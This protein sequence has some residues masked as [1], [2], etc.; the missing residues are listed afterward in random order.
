MV[1][2]LSKNKY[3]LAGV[4]T[5]L[6]F[7]LGLT[8]GFILEN[9]R[10][11]AVD[12]IN[13]GQ[14][15]NYLSL[16]LQYLYLNSLSGQNNC[17]VLSTAL[18]NT[19][20]DLS[21]SLEEVVSFEENKQLASVRQKLVQR[22]YILDNLRYWLLAKE[23]K[24]RCNLDIVTI[25]YFYSSDCSSCPNQGTILTYFK[26]L[27]GEKVLIFPINLDLRADEPTI[28]IALSQ[29]NVTKYPTLVIA[30]TKYEG[31][32]KRDQLQEIICTSLHNASP[33]PSS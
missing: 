6:I 23:S 7:S 2:E 29:F 13:K 3:I 5:I 17:P 10:Y 27:F 8:L 9:Y 20:Q 15:V 32:L 4:L 31:V 21:A 30:D 16:Q 18:K 14:D 25:L 12:E 28:D 11:T 19:V 24:Q 26:N 22:R 1:R 33:C